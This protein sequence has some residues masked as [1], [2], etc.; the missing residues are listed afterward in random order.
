MS[1]L[2]LSKHDCMKIFLETRYIHNVYTNP[3]SDSVLEDYLL[4]DDDIEDE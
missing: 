3:L 4:Q 2:I 1:K